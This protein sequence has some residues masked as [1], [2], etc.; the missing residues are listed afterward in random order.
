MSRISSIGWNKCFAIITTIGIATPVLAGHDLSG[1][2]RELQRKTCALS[3]AI[4]HG[5]RAAPSY[6]CLLMESARLSALVDQAACSLSVP[7]GS[8]KTE[9]LLRHAERQA[10]VVCDLLEDVDDHCSVPKTIRKR[11]NHL[12]E[13][14]E[15]DIDDLADAVADCGDDHHRH[16]RSVF[17]N[18]PRQGG[19]GLWIRR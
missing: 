17:G 10:E 1:E 5:Y 11:T 15:D 14:I 8:R 9:H 12:I 18:V 2:A 3:A 16:H 4:Q 19:W 13:C 6:S 7:Y